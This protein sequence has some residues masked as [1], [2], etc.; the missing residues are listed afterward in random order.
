MGT[1]HEDVFTFMA[2]SGRI[3]LG[4]RNV[5]DKFC[6]ENQNTN[7]MFN[8]SPPSPQ[9]CNLW[10]N[11]KEHGAARDNTDDNI[12]R[13]MRFARW[14]SKATYTHSEYVVLIAFARQLW[15][16]ERASMLRLYKAQTKSSPRDIIITIYVSDV[17]TF[18]CVHVR[19][20]NKS[21]QNLKSSAKS[22]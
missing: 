4:I 20:F 22:L 15:F 16:R 17:E 12:T 3:I 13:R 21:I 7:F 1:L 19:I 2:I 5:S 18:Q 8:N 14:I 10:D 6:T 9:S 11:G